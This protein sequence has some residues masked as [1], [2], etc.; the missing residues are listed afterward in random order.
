MRRDPVRRF[1]ARGPVL[2]QA[3]I[4]APPPA[5]GEIIRT[6]I[7]NDFTGIQYEVGR[8]TEMVK[9]SKSE[10]SVVEMAGLIAVGA[11]QAAEDLGYEVNDDNRALVHLEGI[12][13]YLCDAFVFH[14]DPT[15]IEWV[16]HP[17][18][19]I[20]LKRMPA[21]LL[22][23]IWIPIRDGMARARGVK[24][25]NGRMVPKMHGDCEEATAVCLSLAVALDIVS[26]DGTVREEFGGDKESLHHI[27]GSCWACG[28]W[29]HMDVTQPRRLAFGEH[30]E[31]KSRDHVELPVYEEAA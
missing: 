21:E 31:F 1:P 4:S 20:R 15:D 14:P 5:E 30:L 13:L 16:R 26:P 2:G 22:D 24:P 27:W 8:V 3:A 11:T 7:P 10:E 6:K 12:W 17:R 29:Y 9:G 19:Q 25:G 18:Y 28:D 23:P